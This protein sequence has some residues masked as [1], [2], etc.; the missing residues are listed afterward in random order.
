MALVAGGKH[1]Q[2]DTYSTIGL[3]AGLL[4]LYFT[5]IAWIDS[6][7][8]FLF[9]GIIIITGI[10]ILRKTIANLLDKADEAL[11][12]DMASELNEKRSADWIDIHNAKVIK[13]G[14]FLY[15]DCDLTLPWFY[16]IEKGHQEG[17][18]LREILEK[19]Y[20][21]RI[22]LTIHLD[23]CT[24]FEQAKCRSC[25]CKTCKMR[26]EE[27]VAIEPITLATFIENTNERDH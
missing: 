13:Y 21:D 1:L 20:A 9:G 11:L 19:K 7:L 27:F 2:S 22:Q 12:N 3:V 14:N 6:A 17:A 25:G 16:T 24:V 18:R 5:G 10:S 8:A 26:R 15:M 4:V 23:P